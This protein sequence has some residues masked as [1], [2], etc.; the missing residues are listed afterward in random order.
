M[1]KHTTTKSF[2][3]VQQ[4]ISFFTYRS[5]RF[6][7]F[8]GHEGNVFVK[9]TRG[10]SF[11]YGGKPRKSSGLPHSSVRRRVH[12]CLLRVLADWYEWKA[13]TCSVALK[14]RDTRPDIC[15]F[16]RSRRQSC[17]LAV[18]LQTQTDRPTLVKMSLSLSPNP[19]I[20]YCV[21]P[22]NPGLGSPTC[23]MPIAPDLTIFPTDTAG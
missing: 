13:G 17:L 9:G 15:V 19:K 11:K 18:L 2:Q 3:A 16:L 7:C 6:A 12:S 21:L 10:M 8:T 14:S 20:W 22:R 1:A 23:C 4:F 5:D